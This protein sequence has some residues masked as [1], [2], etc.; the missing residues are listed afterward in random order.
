MNFSIYLKDELVIQLEA[1]AKREKVSRNN[2]INQAVEHFIKEHEAS[3]W[4]EEILNWE[5][6]PEFELPK[7]DELIP[8]SEEIF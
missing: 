8:P 7:N 3:H 4:G 6:C 1:I 5:G 2:L